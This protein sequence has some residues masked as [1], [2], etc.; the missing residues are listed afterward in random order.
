MTYG[1]MY[2]FV[3]LS[4]PVW[5]TSR[6]LVPP[7]GQALLCFVSVNLQCVSLVSVFVGHRIAQIWYHPGN[8]YME[9]LSSKTE[10]QDETNLQAS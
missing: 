9:S 1:E 3:Q 6:F 10:T 8:Q 4:H 7:S 2:P 5:S